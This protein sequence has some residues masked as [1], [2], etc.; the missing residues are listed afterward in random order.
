MKATKAELELSKEGIRKDY[1]ELF[2][3]LNSGKFKYKNYFGNGRTLIGKTYEELEQ[4]FTEGRLGKQ[5]NTLFEQ[6]Q[7][8]VEEGEDVE[9]MLEDLEQQWK[10]TW[11]GT[12]QESIADSII[13]GL[14]SGYTAVEDFAGDIEK[15]LQ[16]AILNAIKYQVLQEPPQQLYD[17]FAN[18]A[19]SDG[20][21]TGAEA[22]QIKAMYETLVGNA[23][24]A[25]NAFSGV[26]DQGSGV[27]DQDAIAN[28][29]GLQG[30][31][32]RELTEATAS[33]LTGLYRATFDIQKQHLI[34][35]QDRQRMDQKNL[36]HTLKIMQS[37]AMIE[38]NTANTVKEL[39]KAVIELKDINSNT[40]PTSTGYDRGF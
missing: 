36:S 17:Q 40:K 4:L 29:S 6:L 38:A 25:Y 10:E 5:G 11:T 14:Q 39:E 23:L 28:Q 15:L 22:E 21:L 18:F 13:S 16:G 2:N 33:E 27:L 30:A 19:E 3:E 1:H 35:D 26:L 9:A 32:R 12:T 31:I 34:V 7:K 20:E 24:D 37:N 8:L